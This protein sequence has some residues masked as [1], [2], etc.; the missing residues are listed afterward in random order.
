MIP[1]KPMKRKIMLGDREVEYELIGKRVKNI[2]LR[3][4]SDMSITV[5]A[6]KSVQISVIERFLHSKADFI[7]RALDRFQREREKNSG[8]GYVNNDIVKIFGESFALKVRRGEHTTVEKREGTVD[9]TVKDAEDVDERVNAINKFLRGELYAQVDE[10]LFGVLGRFEDLEIAPPRITVRDMKT[11][12]GSCNSEKG[13]VS[14]NLRLVRYPRECLEFVLCHELCH[15]VHPNH[16]K[17]FYLLLDSAMP[18]WRARAKK[19]KE[20]C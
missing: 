14:I 4:R 8:M 20:G 7:C 6:A 15:L 18:D 16:S 2:N 19:L 9:V 1:S 13:R 5:S 11:R 10:M 3:I 12:W 17:D